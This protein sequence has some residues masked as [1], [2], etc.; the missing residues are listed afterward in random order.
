[1]KQ[2]ADANLR[3]GGGAGGGPH[4][5]MPA[6]ASPGAAGG[7]SSRST[8]S[9]GTSRVWPTSVYQLRPGVNDSWNSYQVIPDPPPCTLSPAPCALLSWLHALPV[10]SVGKLAEPV[11]RSPCPQGSCDGGLD[12]PSHCQPRPHTGTHS[13]GNRTHTPAHTRS[14]TPP[15][16]LSSPPSPIQAANRGK[17]ATVAE[18]KAARQALHDAR[19][20][21]LARAGP[22]EREML[23]RMMGGAP[24]VSR[25]I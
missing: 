5:A 24:S 10:R 21:L 6:E 2:D 17:Q 9:T 13:P 11:P 16:D 14:Q 12:A 20:Q 15:H 18:W 7:G 4:G 25:P 22:R 19:S 1:V 23:L 3:K 8:P